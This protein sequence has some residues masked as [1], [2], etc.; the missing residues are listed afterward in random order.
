MR[1][2]TSHF[3]NPQ[4]IPVTFLELD[5]ISNSDL[6]F[7]YFSTQTNGRVDIL[8][9]FHRP[10]ANLPVNDKETINTRDEIF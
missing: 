4:N 3:E 6:H 9:N 10:I 2:E 5:A 7:T 8:R 1:I